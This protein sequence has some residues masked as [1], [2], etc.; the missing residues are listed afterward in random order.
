MTPC[1]RRAYGDL[2]P[3]EIHGFLRGLPGVSTVCHERWKSFRARAP[4]EEAML[5]AADT[6]IGRTEWDRAWATAYCP[7][8]RYRRVD[9]ILRPQFHG[10]EPWSAEECRPDQI[11]TVAGCEPLKGLHVLVEA[12]YRLKPLFPGLAVNVAGAGFLPRP[13]NDYARYVLDRI[14]RCGL[15][16]AFTFLGQLDAAALVRQLRRAHCYALPSFM[17]N[18][19]NALQE[20]MLVGAPCV[21]STAGGTPSILVAERSGLAFPAGDAALLAGQIGRILRDE[22]LAKRLSRE[23]RAAAAVRNDPARVEAQLLGAYEE[24]AGGCAKRRHA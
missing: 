7:D 20:A 21:A 1:A 17:E 19:S 10:T 4:Y 22:R 2:L 6:V 12:A 8:V 24:L 18:S 15:E 16:S 14:D 23:A 13:A 11:F 9:E 3:A 5:C